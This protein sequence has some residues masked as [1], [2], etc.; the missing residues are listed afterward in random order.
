M[1]YVSQFAAR[2]VLKT[3]TMERAF[4]EPAHE[5]AQRIREGFPRLSCFD[6]SS[7]PKGRAVKMGSTIEYD[8]ARR[9]VPRHL[10]VD[11]T[12]NLIEPVAIL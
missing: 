4:G 9:A 6:Q 10:N 5:L 11:E 3:G 7:W 1:A 8:N 2:R 12:M